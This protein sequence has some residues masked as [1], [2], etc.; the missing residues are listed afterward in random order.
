[1]KKLILFLSVS[2]VVSFSSLAF[3]RDLALSDK[4]FFK[5]LGVPILQSHPRLNMAY[6]DISGVSEER[7]HQVTHSLGRCGGFEE[8][9]DSLEVK[10]LNITKD[11]EKLESKLQ[12]D[13]QVSKQQLKVLS[14]VQFRPIIKERLDEVSVENLKVN[15]QWLQNFGTRYH[16]GSRANV[17]VDA[18][19]E[20]L[21]AMMAT[22]RIP[23]KIEKISHSRTSQNSLRLTFVG[24][25]EPKKKVILGAHFDSIAGWFGGG[26]APGADD[27]ASGSSNLIEVARILS[28]YDAPERTLEFY[29]YAGEEGGLIGSAE[30]ASDYESRGEEVL[31]VMQLDMTLYPGDGPF[32]LGSVS[33]FTTPWVR[34][35]VK[36][37]NDVY[38][39]FQ[40]NEFE[41]GYGC[42]DH[43]SWYRR[44]YS[45][46]APFEARMNSMNRD[47][48]TSRDRIQ[49]SYN[50]E[51]SSAFTKMALAFAMEM[52]RR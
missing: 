48:H 27:N 30:I 21:E 12:Q 44:G 20:K 36:E 26:D 17:P 8:M 2:S 23:Y 45:T 14:A 6:G 11:L 49:P 4:E 3:G 35:L 32:I 43:A 13:K 19:K 25:K 7:L 42:S 9:G 51:H 24:S 40:I 47:I 18:L 52:D 38:F 34:D 10:S 15:V 41:C 29:W 46:V 16:K 5:A 50:F 1:M 28:K 39:Q 22:S 33:D 37:L 31:A